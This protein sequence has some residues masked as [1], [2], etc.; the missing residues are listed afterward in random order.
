[1]G[2]ALDTRFLYLC[3]FGMFILLIL[4][5]AVRY[6]KVGVLG[7][8]VQNMMLMFVD[9]K[10]RSSK[11]ILSHIY[12]LVGLSYPLWIS[13]INKFSIQQ[14]S[15]VVTVGI[16]DSLASII[17][18]HFGR[19]KWPGPSKKSIEGSLAFAI[20]QIL[21]FAVLH[22]LNVFDMLYGLNPYLIVFT[23]ISSA[24]VEALAN[25][26][27]NLLLPFIVYPCLVLVQ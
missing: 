23:S 8:A 20:S 25:D 10:D 15:G 14:Y 21:F 11:L 2:L 4:I 16:G 27:D 1:L 7:S 22:F 13:D 24:Y 26:N 12:L 9:E 17:G 5:E 19:H 6:F 18:S 3:S